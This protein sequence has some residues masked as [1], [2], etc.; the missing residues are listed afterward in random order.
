MQRSRNRY[1]REYE[2]VEDR[3]LA[4]EI[5]RLVAGERYRLSTHQPNL[6]YLIHSFG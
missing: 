2:I 5:V 4:R 3:T 6:R 1:H